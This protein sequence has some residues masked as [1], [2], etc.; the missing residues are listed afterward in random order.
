MNVIEC[1]EEIEMVAIVLVNYNGSKDTIQCIKSLLNLNF[2]DFKIVI[3]DNAS[4]LN[5]LQELEA[6]LFTYGITTKQSKLITYLNAK[7][8]LLISSFNGGFAFANNIGIKFAM[9]NF[10]NLEY[11]W[12]LN[13]DTLVFPD[14][15]TALVNYMK[16]ANPKIGLLG[17]KLLF[18]DNP[19]IIQAIGGLYNPVWAKV[20]HLGAYE[21]DKGQY[22]DK[23]PSIDYIIGASMF[24]RKSFIFDVGFMSE[25]YFL[26]FEELDWIL[27]G[28]AK[29]WSFAYIPIKV[30]HREGGSTHGNSKIISEIAEKCIIRNRILF[31]KKFYSKY[32]FTVLLACFASILSRLLHGNIRRAQIL[33][34][35]YM[36]SI[37]HIFKF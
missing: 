26:Y 7:I 22:D 9:N 8:T 4:A 28:K 27:R 11:L 24:V 14:T 19:Q 30:L 3:V 32:L 37:F 10:D 36:K 20:K 21:E 23:S 18:Y 29:G 16:S 6:G 35:E 13:N 15:L 33:F 5:S 12:L 2:L 17:N 34:N 31:T 25:D 1:Y